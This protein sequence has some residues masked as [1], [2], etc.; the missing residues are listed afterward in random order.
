MKKF[1]EEDKKR[2]AQEVIK[3]GRKYGLPTSPK[4]DAKKK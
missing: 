2:I 1:T 3:T 4:K